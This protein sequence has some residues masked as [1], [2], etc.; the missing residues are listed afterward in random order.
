M[1]SVKIA[2]V[3]NVWVRLINFALKGDV[4][5]GHKHPFDHISLLARGSVACVVADQ[6]SVFQAPHLIFIAREHEHKFTALEDDTVLSC[7]HAVRSGQREQDIVDPDMYPNGVLSAEEARV[8]QRT[9]DTG[10]IPL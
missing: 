9:L 8:L 2:T 5:D 10:S 4:M 1:I 3:A 6:E 7:I